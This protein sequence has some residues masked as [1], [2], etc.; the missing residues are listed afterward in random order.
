MIP[1]KT[2]VKHSIEKGYQ[3]IKVLSVQLNAYLI[4]EVFKGISVEH[5]VGTFTRHQT[6]FVSGL[7][8]G[9]GLAGGAWAALSLWTGSLSLWGSLGYTLGL[10]TAPVW[11]SGPPVGRPALAPWGGPCTVPLPWCAD[12]TSG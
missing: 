2:P 8:G 4:E 11:N 3:V 10:V 12:A 9:V 6:K 5:I 1:D 7:L